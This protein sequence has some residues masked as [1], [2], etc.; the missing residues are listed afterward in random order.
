MNSPLHLL[1]PTGTRP[2][3]FPLEPALAQ[4]FN[5][6]RIKS[7]SSG[8]LTQ[9]ETLL[10][11]HFLNLQMPTLIPSTRA[12]TKRP[13][14]VMPKRYHP[15][16]NYHLPACLPPK[17]RMQ[18]QQTKSLPLSI[19]RQ[20]LNRKRKA[21]YNT[22]IPQPPTKKRRRACNTSFDLDTIL[23]SGEMVTE[24]P[25]VKGGRFL[26]CCSHCSR[27][28]WAKPTE[29]EGRFVYNHECSSLPRRQYVV[30]G[31]HRKC[32]FEHSYACIDFLT[33]PRRIPKR[34]R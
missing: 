16:Q 5:S 26:M 27:V 24:I 2:Q 7:E 1:D 29:R 13:L 14:T 19:P 21:S 23:D 33:N 18:H 25:T 6:Q 32:P 4:F 11:D 22:S 17:I 15:T 8:D 10:L 20:N 3:H 34:T 30:G 31:F 12:S 28:F 9:K